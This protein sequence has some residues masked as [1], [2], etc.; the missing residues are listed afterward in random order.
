MQLSDENDKA[1]EV[2]APKELDNSL[3]GRVAEGSEEPITKIKIWERKLLDFSLRNSLLNFRITRSTL[4]IM[5]SDLGELE[6]RLSDGKE[7]RIM[8]IP[9]EWT[10]LS[11]T[12]KCL[13]LK[14]KKTS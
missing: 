8:E 6:D 11:A 14:M 3:L 2:S 1:E 4:Q 13:K 5:V 7:F 9:S 12:L 10:F